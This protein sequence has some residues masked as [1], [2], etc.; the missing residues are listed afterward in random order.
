MSV[1]TLAQRIMEGT[2]ARNSKLKAIAGLRKTIKQAKKGLAQRECKLMCLENSLLITSL[3]QKPEPINFDRIA[4]KKEIEVVKIVAARL[5]EARLL[6]GHKTSEAAALLGV[7]SCDLQMIEG[8]AG[9]GYVPLWLIKRAAETYCVPSDYLFGLIEDWDAADGE[10]FLSRNHL[11]ALQRQEF[12]NFTTT[13]AE[14]IKQDVRLKAINTAVVA[15]GL[16]VQHINDVF[17]Q[18]RQLN[19][20][21]FDN[22]PGGARVLRQI[23]LAEELGQHATA[24]LTK[25]KCLPESLAAHAEQMEELF[26]NN[27]G[28]FT[29]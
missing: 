25:Y 23:Q 21:V 14:Q 3:S 2:D 18:F 22:L 9:V 12:E 29:D 6:C 1:P 4:D 24:A 15:F 7:T 13:A 20:S 5:R 26:P 27:S 19:Y 28:S 16:A 8:V 11:A 17:T 10:A